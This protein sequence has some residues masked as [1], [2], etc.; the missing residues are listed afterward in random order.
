MQA[1]AIAA[2]AARMAQIAARMALGLRLGGI[3]AMAGVWAQNRLGS[4]WD[5]ATNYYAM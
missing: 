3:G 5:Y 4:M 1:A 2:I